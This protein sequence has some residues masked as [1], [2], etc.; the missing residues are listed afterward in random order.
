[1]E[2]FTRRYIDRIA[3]LLA[4]MYNTR[5]HN[6]I[7]A[8]VLRVLFDDDSD[9]L[10]STADSPLWRT[11]TVTS[12]HIMPGGIVDER[13]FRRIRMASGRWDC[14]RSAGRSP[15]QTCSYDIIEDII[16]YCCDRRT[17]DSRFSKGP[18]SIRRAHAWTPHNKILRVI[19]I[20]LITRVPVRLCVYRVYWK[21]EFFAEFNTRSRA[22]FRAPFD[23]IPY[24]T[25][26]VRLPSQDGLP[27]NAFYD[28]YV[29]RLFYTLACQ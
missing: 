26:C 8:I 4:Q 23:N 22:E 25:C 14:L 28:K 13:L 12:Q 17:C 9:A 27:K 16:R 7:S 24:Y 18:H 10:I 19:V 29:C 2:R 6:R 1:M 3:R 21:N 5:A 15:R 11:C 20:T